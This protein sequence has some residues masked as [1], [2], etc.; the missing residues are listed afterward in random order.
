MYIMLPLRCTGLIDLY[1]CLIYLS[2]AEDSKRYSIFLGNIIMIHIINIVKVGK[3]IQP[4]LSYLSRNV[5][6]DRGATI[7]VR[8][9]LKIF[10]MRSSL[11]R[12]ASVINLAN[13]TQP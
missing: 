13:S 4:C 11:T 10:F 12:L 8:L 1:F 9:V 5:L 7:Y 2:S 6:D 3:L